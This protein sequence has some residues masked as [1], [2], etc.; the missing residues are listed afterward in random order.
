[1]ADH[2]YLLVAKVELEELSRAFRNHNATT[3]VVLGILFI[4]LIAGLVGLYL[5]N[6][7]REERQH[8]ASHPKLFRELSDAHKLSQEERRRL[9]EL[10]RII[11]ARH[12]DY[13]FVRF[14]LM[15]QAIESWIQQNPEQSPDPLY[16]LRRRLF[17]PLPRHSLSAS[18]ELPVPEGKNLA[19]A[20]EEADDDKPTESDEAMRPQG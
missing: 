3:S 11:R 12:A 7:N 18:T 13:M 14:D 2:A 16:A 9:K 6:R 17:E 15:D 4:L 19:T 1:M 5:R 8:F 10:A 20:T